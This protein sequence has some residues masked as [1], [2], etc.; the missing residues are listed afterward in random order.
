MQLTYE[1]M[2]VGHVTLLCYVNILYTMVKWSSYSTESATAQVSQCIHS[3]WSQSRETKLQS[4]KWTSFGELSS[5]GAI[6]VDKDGFV[7]VSNF[8]AVAR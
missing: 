7:Y 5:P 8:A 1:H 4:N 3:I 2:K 6:V